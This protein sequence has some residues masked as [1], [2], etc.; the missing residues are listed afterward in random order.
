VDAIL[1]AARAVGM[2]EDWTRALIQGSLLRDATGRYEGAVRLLQERP[3]PEGAV[4]K[5]L[6]NLFYARSLDVYQS[7]LRRERRERIASRQ[8]AGIELWTPEQ[9]GEASLAALQEAWSLRGELG[10]LPISRF[11]EYLIPNDYPEEVRGTLRDALTY[12]YVDRL[13]P[14]EAMTEEAVAA[15]RDL[16]SWHLAAGRRAAALEAKLR[17]AGLRHWDAEDRKAFRQE[18]KK[19]LEAFRDLPWWSMG[20]ATLASLEREDE[21]P[22]HLRRAREIALTGREAFPASLGADRCRRIVE[23][24]EVQAFHLE[25]MISDGLGRRSIQ[26]THTNLPRLHFRAYGIDPRRSHRRGS[27]DGGGWCASPGSSAGP[28]RR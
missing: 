28:G 15:L 10:D 20:M 5:V 8:E 1:A 21:E 13:A 12:L 7:T 22:G 2:E 26:V 18:L 23:E 19:D 6:L 14:E 4:H 27:E 9:I 11:R 3:W 24:I 16:E 25:A 17:G